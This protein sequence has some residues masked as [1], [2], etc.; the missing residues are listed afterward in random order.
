MV[1]KIIPD[2]I[3]QHKNTC[4]NAIR[5][6]FCHCIEHQEGN[7][8]YSRG[9]SSSR[10]GCILPTVWLRPEHI[11]LIPPPQPLC[12]PL[13]AHLPPSR[14]SQSTPATWVA[15]VSVTWGTLT[16]YLVLDTPQS[17][18]GALSPHFEPCSLLPAFLLGHC[19]CLPIEETGQPWLQNW[20]RRH[21]LRDLCGGS[22]TFNL[23][24]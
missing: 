7:R 5:S 18:W 16:C 11:W 1:S 15:Q 12:C 22:E 8:P 20:R 3:S 14:Y 17:F 4:S 9:D 13:P 2:C 23:P 6:K 24:N 19:Y 10:A 21:T